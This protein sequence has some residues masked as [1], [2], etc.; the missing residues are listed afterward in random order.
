MTI[1]VLVVLILL[2]LFLMS[3]TERF[4]DKKDTVDIDE[5]E[6]NLSEYERVENV[7]VS[8]DVMEKI[9]LA[10]NKRVSEL[11]GL[12]T[13]IVQTSEV[14]KFKHIATGDE[15]YRCM[16]MVVKHGGFP[17]AFAVSSDVRI[18]NDPNRVN[19]NDYNMQATLRTLGVDPVDV[20][21]EFIDEETGKIDAVKL[22]MTKYAN[23]VSRSNPLV[24]VISLR[25][26]PLDVKKPTDT[27]MFTSDF[28]I[29]EFEDYTKV[30]ENELNYIKNTPLIE[31]T[32][33]SA[34]DMYGRPKM[35]ENN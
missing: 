2:V 9:V 28:D 29:K 12:C 16:F 32:V 22:I 1:L 33:L 35:L 21:I 15:V 23:E 14:R 8:N 25:T 11:T 3:R 6:L 17:Y 30:R 24:V 34:E 31:K 4:S 10:V 26:Q 7:K 19:W 20:P 5:N 27:K 18:M 13:Y